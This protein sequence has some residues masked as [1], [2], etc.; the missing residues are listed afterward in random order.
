MK[1]LNQSSNQSRDKQVIRRA[2]KE[3]SYEKAAYNGAYSGVLMQCGKAAL[4]PV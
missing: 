2:H 3:L 1:N 4:V